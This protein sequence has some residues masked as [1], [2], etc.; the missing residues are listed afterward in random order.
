MANGKV[1]G[2]DQEKKN[3]R[4]MVNEWHTEETN[5]EF[6]NDECRTAQ[7]QGAAPSA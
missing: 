1:K 6:R 7:S 2:R 3:G 4:L 5:G